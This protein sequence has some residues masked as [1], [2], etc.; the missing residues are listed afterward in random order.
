MSSEERPTLQIVIE[1]LRHVGWFVLRSPSSA[2]PTPE[3]SS[4]RCRP[5]LFAVLLLSSEL[6][7]SAG[8]LRRA[9]IVLLTG[10]ELVC[11]S[12]WSS[13]GR[14]WSGGRTAKKNLAATAQRPQPVSRGHEID[15]RR[16]S[17]SSTEREDSARAGQALV[18]SS[19]WQHGRRHSAKS[20]QGNQPP[21]RGGIEE[22][23]RLTRHSLR[24]HK[25]VNGLAMARSWRFLCSGLVGPSFVYMHGL[26]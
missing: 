13:G 24:W 20:R 7:H 6:Y 15:D 3:T 17:S 1:D 5:V 9:V 8:V 14:R 2:R 22:V 19:T 25:L 4:D 11:A 18:A 21:Q 23:S 12:W 26:S 10:D 16:L